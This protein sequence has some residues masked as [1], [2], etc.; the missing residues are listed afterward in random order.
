[1]D[2]EQKKPGKYQRQVSEQFYIQLQKQH[3][4]FLEQ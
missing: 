4:K 1:M 2:E 3:E